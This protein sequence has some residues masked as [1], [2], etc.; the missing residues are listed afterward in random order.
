MAKE[1]D[2]RRWRGLVLALGLTV[3]AAAQAADGEAVFAQRL[4][5][6]KA[7]GK[8]FYLGLGRVAKGSTPLGPDTVTA[9][10]TVAS[11]AAKIEPGLF[12]PGS[13]VGASHMKPAIFDDPARVAALTEQ[14]R[15]AVAK[16]PAAAKSGD[17]AVLAAAYAAANQACVA[18]HKDFRIDE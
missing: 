8:P 18:C 13:I 11:L 7:L 1:I 9:A 10:D 3:G 5:T 14:V 12:A 2:M 17:Q 4:D 6:M 16:L 15:A